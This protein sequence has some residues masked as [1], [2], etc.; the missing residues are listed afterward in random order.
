[1]DDF[2][3]PLKRCSKCGVTKPATL[4]YFHKR[5]DRKSGL[6][7]E[8][9]ICNHRKT[10]LYYEDHKE[11]V[12]DRISRYA[13]EHPELRRQIA[14]RYYYNNQE[15][16]K[17]RAREY[18]AR[19]PEVV[20]AYNERFKS[21]NPEYSKQYRERN[22]DELRKTGREYYAN[23]KQAALIRW[24]KR[25]ALKKNAPGS[26]TQADIELQ[27][28]SQKGKCWH[29]GKSVGDDYHID[30]LIP[31]SRGGSNAPENLVIS[32]PK[33]NLSKHNKLPHEWNR[34]LF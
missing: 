7:S 5:S 11:A 6:T 28:R 14:S 2:T 4:E 3:I 16:E 12:L 18:R 9:K 10:Q 1:M 24:R 19:R 8:C 25:D 27:Y 26:H 34:R 22:A 13:K 17:A 23:H 15:K 20:K 32:C 21:E 29:C 33:C 30:H 31:L